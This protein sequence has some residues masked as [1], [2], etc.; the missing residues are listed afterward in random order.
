MISRRH[1]LTTT[2][3]LAV[4]AGLPLPAFAQATPKRGGT[5]TATWGG[6]EPQALFV[7]PGGGSSPYFTSTKIL[8]RLLRLDA[9][10]NFQ[11]V[12][13]LDVTPAAD[14]KSYTIKLRPNVTW[15]DGKPFTAD[16]VVF[17]ALSYWKPISA[18]LA[19]KALT[20]AEA[21]DPLT[22]KLTFN[23]TVPEFFLKSVLSGKAGLVIPKHIYD[24]KELLTNPAN[25]SPVGTGPWKVKE[26]VRGSHVELSRNEAYW[27]AGKPYVD[28][29]VIRWWRDPASRSAAFEAGQLDIGCFNPIPV[30]DIKRLEA[31]KKFVSTT[32]GYENSAWIA[33][34]EFNS[35]RDITKNVAV[36]QAL[37]HA[38]DREFIGDTIFFG[39]AKAATG[40]IPSSNSLFYTKDV[41]QYPFDPELAAKKLDAAG[42][43][44]K[45]K[46]RFKLSVVS[47]GW[48][49]E[50]VKMGQYLKQ[51]LEDVGVEVDLA[52]PDR[53]TS[54]KRIYGDY[55]YDIAISNNSGPVELVPY[56]TQFV[57]SDGIVK[58][59]A[60][61]N[62]NGHADPKLDAIV[63]S[64][65]T[66]VD[67]VKRK[68][69]AVE[70]QQV[71][72]KELPITALV[73]IQSVTVARADV[74]DHSQDAD[75]MGESWSRVWLDR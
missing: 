55:D 11:P 2:A 61:R 26:W 50:N 4:A 12:L 36:R 46:T 51:A 73:D 43:P 6:F 68:A 3:G 71:V 23:T 32:Q 60:F 34:V 19:L 27:D 66:N 24:G 45:G 52:I 38:I 20:G 13:A 70:F 65:A 7:P 64:L 31:S 8:E 29:L 54:L 10:L 22:V 37:M 42:Y 15:H 53:A 1:F 21:V 67:P 59:A 5:L 74:R 9:K 47:A 58:G 25:N 28:R 75:F 17:N 18:G 48:F 69:L 35:R 16:D 30:P 57:T 44:L 63:E 56:W 72:A 14:F 49:E 62:A 33:S 39:L 41:E 40:F